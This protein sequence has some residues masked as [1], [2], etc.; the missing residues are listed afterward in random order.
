MSDL[1]TPAGYY[2]QLGH[3]SSDGKEFFMTEAYAKDVE[4]VNT[5]TAE[6]E[7]LNQVGDTFD[8][9]D[10]YSLQTPDP[11]NDGQACYITLDRVLY[12]AT[13]CVREVV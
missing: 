7:R 9:P 1:F 11:S 13:D 6:V 3:R 10:P 4:E 5:L 12:Q 2:L 8:E